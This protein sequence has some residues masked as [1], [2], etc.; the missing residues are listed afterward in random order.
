[1]RTGCEPHNRDRCEAESASGILEGMLKDMLQSTRFPISDEGPPESIVLL[2]CCFA[3][4]FEDEVRYAWAIA[5]TSKEVTRRD[6]E[7][8]QVAGARGAPL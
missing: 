6:V 2:H 7:C 8:T 1:M 5:P 4:G 3:E